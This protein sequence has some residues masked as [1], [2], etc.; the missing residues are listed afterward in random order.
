[1]STLPGRARAV[2]I[3]AGIVGNSL[4]YHLHRLG[5]TRHRADRQGPAAQPRRLDRARLELHLPGRPLQ[6]DDRP[7]ARQRA[8]VPGARRVHRSAAASRSP[9]PRSGCRS[10]A[11]ACRRRQAWGIDGARWSRP[12]QVKEKVPFID[13]THP[14]RRLLTPRASAWST[15]CAPARSCASGRRPPARS[16]SWPNVEVLGIDVEHGRGRAGVRTTR[17]DI[18]AEIVVI[19]CGVWSPQAG[20]HGRRVDPAHPGRAPDDRRRPGARASPTPR[21]RSSSRS[22]ATWTPTCTSA[23]TAPT[24][25]SAPTPT[26]RSCTTPR[27][28]PRSRRRRS[29]RPSSRSPQDD[30]DQ[31][32]EHALELMPEI[33]GDERCGVKYAING[34]LS[35]TPDGMPIL[36]ETPEVKGLWSAAAVWVKEGPG[37]G[38]AVAEWMVARRVRDRPALTPT[39]PASTRTRRRRAHVARAH[40]PRGS[41]RPTASSTRPS[42]GR[43]T[44][45]CGCRPIHA[46]R[47]GARRGVLRDR[48]LG[49]AALVRVERRPARGVRRPRHAAR[50]RVGRALVV[51][52]SSTPSTWRCATGAGMVD[53]TAFAI[54]DIAGPGALDA[55]QRVCDAP[56]GRRRSAGSSTRRCSTPGGGFK[57]DL[58]IMRLGDDHFRVVTGGAHGMADRKWFSDHL[59]AD[60]SRAARPT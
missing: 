2:V 25:R 21:R 31:Q 40:R 34:L 23:S 6:G 43:R 54:F 5:W 58:T 41:T 32:L 10:C 4:V 30:F 59:P 33:V 45:T 15:R 20:A 7:H 52:R 51:A 8:P 53:L 35:L 42:S 12:A 44:A 22:C 56:D 19:A 28:S 18:E 48:R 3:G 1:M 13:E 46:P 17:G 60:G 26:A 14:R 16:P 57:S 9:A 37:V 38:R 36:G 27:R 50:G 47:A 55:V 24:W 49:A 39:S 11:G 29:R